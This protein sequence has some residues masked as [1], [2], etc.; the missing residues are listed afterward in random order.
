[1]ST[2]SSPSPLT[3]GVI[4][5]GRIGRLHAEHLRSRIPGAQL[6]ILADLNPTAVEN[7]ARSL[8]LADRTTD[9]RRVLEHPDVQAVVICSST[10]T[11]AD[12]IEAA[13]AARK[14]IFCEKPIDTDLT[15]IDRA[16]DAVR[17]A[18]VL[19]QV[20][21]NRRFDPS[22]HRI[23]QAVAAGEIGTPRQL[24]ITSR[25]PA[26]PPIDYVRRSGGIFTDMTIHDFDMARFLIGSEVVE[27][28]ATGGVHVDPAIGQAGDI[29]TALVLLKFANGVMGVIENCRQ[30]AYGYDQ[31]VEVFGSRGSIGADNCYPNTATVQGPATIYRD[32][33]LNFFMDRYTQSYLEEM[34]QFVQAVQTGAP[35]P[36]PGDAA[37]V[38]VVMARAARRS[39]NENRPVKLE[40][41]G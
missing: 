9:P 13:A 41:I 5:T 20:G 21:F 16:L 38:P 8:G 6:R 27:I 29:D 31:R 35:S 25:D 24:R 23:R 17:R 2:P 33:P 12:L 30:A 1:M 26:P 3:L 4:G 14:H 19:L 10:D 32:L 11:H 34:R 28:Y 22:F 18:G 7:C 36:V 15:R 40:E 37:R 39:I